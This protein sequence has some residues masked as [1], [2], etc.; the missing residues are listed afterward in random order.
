MWIAISS[1][2]TLALAIWAW[3]IKHNSDVEK[4]KDDLKKKAEDAKTDS[5][6]TNVFD[7]INR[8]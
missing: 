7:N 3:W 5:D 1:L 2:V 8:M 4:K 6:I